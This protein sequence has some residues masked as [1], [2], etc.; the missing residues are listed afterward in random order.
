M[1]EEVRVV[2]VDDHRDAADMLAAALEVEGY[3]VRSCGD[4]VQ[5]L[6]LVAEFRPHLILLDV[7]MPGM[8]GSELTQELRKRYGDEIVLLAVSGSDPD[9]ERVSRTFEQVDHYFRK[10]IDLAALRKIVPPV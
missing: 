3:S 2:V 5:A 10:P 6:A 8:D 1:I 9:D 4:G 7:N